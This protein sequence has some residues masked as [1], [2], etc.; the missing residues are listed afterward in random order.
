VRSRPLGALLV[1][2]AVVTV[3]ACSDDD[4]S[5]ATSVAVSAAPS[6]SAAPVATSAPVT[7]APTTTE[8][9]ATTAPATTDAPPTTDAPT[10]WERVVPGGDCQCALGGEFAYWVHRGDPTKVM[11][12]FQGGGACFDVNSCQPGGTYKSSTGPEDDPS[13]RP[14]GLLDLTNPANPVAG[15]SIVFVP[16]CTGDVFL[17][18]T[19]HEYSADLTV[20]HVGAIDARAALQGLAATCPDATQVFVAGESAGG[21]PVPIVA[22]EAHDLLPNATITALADS[23]GAY[24]DV[25]AV[26]AVIGGVWGTLQGAPQW[27][28]LVGMTAEQYSVPGLFV[29]AGKHDP[30]IRF[31]RHDYAQDSTQAFFGSLAGF[32]ASNLVQLID[33]N[34]QEIEGDGVQV[35]S[36]VAPGDEHTVIGRP[37]LYT[38]TVEGVP[39]VTWIADLLAGTPV[40]DVH[41]VDC[42]GP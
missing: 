11:L 23:S 10:A 2:L 22:G 26:N 42:Q 41:C 20:H 15:W 35:A 34:E 31:A 27:P 18:A 4:A 13:L 32:D 24:P 17:G 28:E 5:P 9:P 14:A 38:E 6:S 29:L 37:E 33:R 7:T 12:Y 19:T 36:Y 8:T 1:A 3:A 21:V 25:P 39:F 30:A 16:Y 40:D